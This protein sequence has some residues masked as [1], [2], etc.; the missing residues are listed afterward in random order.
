MNELWRLFLEYGNAASR[1]SRKIYK[2][3]EA[4]YLA[5]RDA[6]AEI[7]ER[8]RAAL[9]EAARD[10]GPKANTGHV[11]DAQTEGRAA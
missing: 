5:A 8:F 4:E 1:V 3:P 6:K 11:Q 7:R 2:G 9:N 10:A